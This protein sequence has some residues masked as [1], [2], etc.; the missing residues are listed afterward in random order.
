MAHPCHLRNVI[1]VL[2]Y[3]KLL[4]DGSVN[5]LAGHIYSKQ[6]VVLIKAHHRPVVCPTKS[7]QKI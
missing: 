6:S 1:G 4:L 7:K 2:A 5:V 3:Y